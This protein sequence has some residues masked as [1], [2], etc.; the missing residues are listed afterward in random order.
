MGAGGEGALPLASVLA[1]H[2]LA[3]SWHVPDVQDLVETILAKLLHDTSFFEVAEAAQL[4]G[5]PPL[6][7]ACVAFAAK[8]SA[9]RAAVDAGRCSAAVLELLG[10]GPAGGQPAKRQ[11][12]SL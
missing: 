2:E 9:V 4:R 12:L 6:V 8:S 11:R 3:H 7:A 10:K 1:A 5:G